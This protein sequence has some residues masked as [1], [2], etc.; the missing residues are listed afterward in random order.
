MQPMTV[1]QATAD[2]VENKV[3]KSNKNQPDNPLE[4]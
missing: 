4:N 1:T 2:K 3:E